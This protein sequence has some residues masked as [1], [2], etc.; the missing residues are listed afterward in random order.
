MSKKVLI[1]DDEPDVLTYL[2][3]ILQNNDYSPFSADSVKSGMKMLETVV[4]NL[5]CLDIMMPKES[6]ITMY[7]KLRED[8]R[9]KLIPVLI[10]SGIIHNGDFNFR[11]YIT[12][13]R[14]PHPEEILE[15]PV[16]V[17]EF[18][19]L[20]NKLTAETNR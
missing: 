17:D 9:F 12:D 11:S 3:T 8:N 10:I 20:V 19:R 5:I 2:S 13:K 14:I 6:G 15:K 4:P 7:R 1:I 18:I 16:K